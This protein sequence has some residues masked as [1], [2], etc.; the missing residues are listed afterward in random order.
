MNYVTKFYFSD[1]CSCCS[2]VI[3]LIPHIIPQENTA[4]TI[5]EKYYSDFFALLSLS[6]LFWTVLCR[7]GR[8][9]KFLFDFEGEERRV[10][11]FLK[12]EKRFSVRNSFSAISNSSAIWT[13]KNWRLVNFSIWEEQWHNM[14]GVA[15]YYRCILWVLRFRDLRYFYISCC[16]IIIDNICLPIIP[17][18]KEVIL[19]LKWCVYCC[20]I[21]LFLW[22]RRN[23][24][25]FHMDQA[26]KWISKK[27]FKK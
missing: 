3:A 25:N 22:L 10:V 14:M 20:L 24:F 21:S 9:G 2:L 23:Q 18:D 19:F 6:F 16:D 12:S 13:L 15:K 11:S 26:K 17:E 7:S 8:R 5:Y 4:A 27:L 1:R